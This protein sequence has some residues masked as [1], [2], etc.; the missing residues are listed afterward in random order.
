MKKII[1]SFL[2]STLLLLA[3]EKS[4]TT[5]EPL[6]D[7]PVIIQLSSGGEQVVEA[8]NEFGLDIFKAII[9]DESPGKNIFI[10]P[11]SISLALAM[12]YNGA[13]G[14]TEDSM[15]YAL[16]MDHLTSGQINTSYKE[17][18]GGLTSVDEKVIMDIANS[19]WYRQGF[20]V[21]P[22]FLEMNTAYYNADVSEL[23]FNSPDAVSI[24]N[25][26]VSD[27]TNEKIETIINQI[28]PMAVMFL[29]NA[30][31]FKGTWTKEFNPEST[32]DGSFYLTDGTYKT[33]DMMAFQEEI[34]YV[35]N[36]LFQAAEL[37][38]GRGNYSMIV[39]L[40]KGDLSAEELAIHLNPDNWQSWLSSIGT[41]EVQLSL[42]KFTF[43][44]EKNLNDILS[45]M[46]MGIAFDPMLADFTGIN[47]AGG[48]YIS[49][50]KH[51]TFV[52]VNEE[53]T[54][55]AA[56][57]IVGIVGTSVDPNQNP[58]MVVNHPFLFAIREKT[59]NAIVFI[60]KVAEP[61]I[62]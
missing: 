8:S 34:G 51:K 9:A 54:E 28:D 53:G 61:K 42:P 14:Y 4:P 59:T 26:W 3:C 22:A 37:D 18:I 24:I 5:S 49:F 29:I 45:L 10:S 11:T 62:E 38:Y 41:Q 60:G 21:E 1:I 44:Y 16:R 56:V 46:G 2:L 20:Y 55:A 40:P 31:Y 7:E 12:T 43:E 27:N 52:E 39:L 33:V 50:V 19:I 58:V 17:L 15:A 13:N 25:G 57:T 23:D 47:S 35:E 48:L 6:P 32:Y 30:I 36:D